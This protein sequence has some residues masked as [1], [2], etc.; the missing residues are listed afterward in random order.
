MAEKLRLRRDVRDAEAVR[1]LME[2]FTCPYV[3]SQGY[4]VAPKPKLR[5]K[6][7]LLGGSTPLE[8]VKAYIS[9]NIAELLG[10][11]VV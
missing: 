7:K 1:E 6:S 8:Q 10:R 11:T 9:Q 4:E 3:S 2:R 5:L